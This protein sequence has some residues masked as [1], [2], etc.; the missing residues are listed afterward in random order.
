MMCFLGMVAGMV[1]VIG[2]AFGV[3]MWREARVRGKGMREVR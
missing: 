1:S 3:L 2:I